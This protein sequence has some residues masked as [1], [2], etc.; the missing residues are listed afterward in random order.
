MGESMGKL[1]VGRFRPFQKWSANTAFRISCVFILFFF[2]SIQFVPPAESAPGRRRARAVLP[3]NVQEAALA[4]IGRGVSATGTIYPLSEVKLMSRV[5]GQVQEVKV[6][7]GDILLKG[8]ILATL[9]ST[10]QRIQLA[11]AQSELASVR[12]RVKKLKAG[13]RPQEIAA[14]EA[15]VEQVRASLQRSEAELEGAKARLQEAEINAN[16]L[17]A[18][19]KRGVI[20]RQEWL[21]VSTEALRARAEIAERTARISEDR[22]R[23]NVVGEDLKLKRLGSRSEDIEAA[24]ADEQKALQNVLLL[25]TQLDYFNI[26]SPIS[27]VVTERRVEPGE[28]AV[29]RAHLFTLAQIR[30]LRVRARVSALDLTRLKMGQNTLIE[31][32]AFR[33]RIFRGKLSRIY[34]QVD[35]RARQLT[36]E[37][38]LDNSNLELKPG[39]LARLKFEPLMGREVI[40][41]P[42][43]AVTWDGNT[44]RRVGYVY[45]I[46]RKSGKKGGKGGP[47]ARNGQLHKEGDKRLREASGQAEA[48]E[49]EV[50]ARRGGGKKG[51]K[52]GPQYVAVKREV[53]L[54]EMV[55]GRIEILEGLKVGEKVIISA[56]GQL[57]DGKAIRIVN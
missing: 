52:N 38:E 23:I 24:Q 1:A 48:G 55:D 3:V 35:P 34:P 25:Q 45:V 13:F 32:D 19:F 41:L 10:I 18:M 8:Q 28:L 15:G 54:G 53:K 36:V 14:A 7:E 49:R 51:R 50:G 5:E 57:K 37:V 42:V 20:S 33:G 27:G 9:D 2:A 31:L 6:R 4:R 30:K 12:A 11:L 16:S 21:K 44:E 26:Q 29:N 43:P 40:N 46:K 47:G 17:E 39:L 22:A 56:T